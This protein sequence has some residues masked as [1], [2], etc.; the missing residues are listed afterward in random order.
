ME[1]NK[2]SNDVSGDLLVNFNNIVVDGN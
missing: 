1:A 2:N